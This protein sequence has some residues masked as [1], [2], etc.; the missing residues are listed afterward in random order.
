M[1][2][3][4]ETWLWLWTNLSLIFYIT[5]VRANFMKWLW[6]FENLNFL[7]ASV[8]L[9]YGPSSLPYQKCDFSVIMS[10]SKMESP[11]FEKLSI[12]C[13]PFTLHFKVIMHFFIAKLPFILLV[14]KTNMSNPEWTCD[15]CLCVW[16]IRQLEC[17]K[18]PSCGT[19]YL[20]TWWPLQ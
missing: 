19:P 2:T 3:L 13:D 14:E 9:L 5:V 18:Y 16:P 1:T 15:H 10:V 12:V 17:Q 20:E 4:T 7:T 11:S 8:N 6:I